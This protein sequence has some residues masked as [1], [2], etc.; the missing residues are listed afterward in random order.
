[1]EVKPSWLLPFA[2]FAALPFAWPLESSPL[3]EAHMIAI[4]WRNGV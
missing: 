3:Q 2:P 4:E 1:M